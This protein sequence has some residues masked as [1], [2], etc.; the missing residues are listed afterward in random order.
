MPMADR[1]ETEFQLSRT[2]L[3]AR[4]TA[5][6]W[7]TAISCSPSAPGDQIK[8]YPQD[9][10]DWHEIVNETDEPVPFALSYCPLTA[11]AVAWEL[12]ETAENPTYGV[13]GLLLNSNLL[14]YDRET[15]SYWSQALQLGVS[16]PLRE[17][18][19]RNIQVLETTFATVKSMYPDAI[20]M[21]RDT[22]HTRNYDNYPYGTY[23]TD[24]RVLFNVERTD[25]PAASQGTRHRNPYTR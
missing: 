23:R 18:T 8:V 21:T 2:P 20:V 3:S 4:P 13:S 1:E 24:T 9:I 12:S 6:Q 11:S 5:R 15:D 17:A 19:P 22:G 16:G 7:R 25:N 10:M 14:L